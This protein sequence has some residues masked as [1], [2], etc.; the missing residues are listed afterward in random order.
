MSLVFGVSILCSCATFA[1]SMRNSAVFG[2]SFLTAVAATSLRSR[3]NSAAF[4][5]SINDTCDCIFDCTSPSPSES[6][7]V[8]SLNGALRF[9][10]VLR[11]VLLAARLG[12][13]FGCAR[14]ALGVSETWM[15]GFGG[16]RARVDLRRPT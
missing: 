2:V 16:T 8:S 5:V 4:G 14:L 6:E 3:V 9:G 1:R 10:T 11:A 12:R 7:L 13:R 15:R